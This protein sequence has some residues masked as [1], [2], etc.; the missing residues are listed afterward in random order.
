MVLP[1]M[2]TVTCQADVHA[3]TLP[4][5]LSKTRRLLSTSQLLAAFPEDV[6]LPKDL[7]SRG[8]PLVALLL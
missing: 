2:V 1:V 4:D 5:E 6:L 7:F 3:S 8:P